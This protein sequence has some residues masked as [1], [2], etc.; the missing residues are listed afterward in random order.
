MTPPRVPHGYHSV[1][2]YLVLDGAAKALD[3]YKE[4][5]GA[6]EVMRLGGPDGKIGHAEIE[7]G[8][9]RIMLADENPAFDAHAPGRFGGSPISI[10][11]YVAEVD[12]VVAKTVAAGATLRREV[13]D[14]F[15]GDRMG[16]ILDPFGHTWHISTHV[17]DVSPEEIE[18]RLQEMTKNA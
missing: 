14:K 9:S 15:Y 7:I 2:P 5:F 8:D 18:R 1:T 17:E 6:K 10:V 3:W 13:E 12:S 11:L 4:A 16:T